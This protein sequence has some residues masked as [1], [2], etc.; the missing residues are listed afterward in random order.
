MAIANLESPAQRIG[1]KKGRILK[2]VDPV[3]SLGKVGVN[4]DFQ[5]NQGATVVYR[6]MVVKGGSAAQPNRFFLDG[7]GDRAQSY[8]NQHLV[9]DGITP[10]AESVTTVDYRATVRNYAVLYGYSAEHAML[11]EDGQEIPK[12]M[13]KQCG[14]RLGLVYEMALFNVLKACTNKYFG[15]SGTSRATVNGPLSLNKLREIA[16]GLRLN[17]AETLTTMTQKGKAGLYGTAPVQGNS[18]PVWIHTNQIPDL[19]FLPKYKSV[20]EYGD[21]SMAVDNEVG[22]CGEFRFIASPELI[23]IQNSGAAVAGAAT[24]IKSTTGTFADVYQVII[25]SQ[26]AWGHIGVAADLMKV[27]ELKPGDADKADQL[28]QRGYVGCSSYYHAIILNPLQM[29]VGEFATRDLAE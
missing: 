5:R 26:D 11:H 12:F 14:Q 18:Y 29:A 3:I 16:R 6:R 19:D 28:G 15:G 22:S 13:Y 4:D 25:G 1:L 27:Y 7:D 23:P 20:H 8:I 9:S 17:H 21:P 24:P 2:H 10:D